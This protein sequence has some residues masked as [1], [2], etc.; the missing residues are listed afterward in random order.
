MAYSMYEATVP[1]LAHAL[2]SLRGVLQKGEQWAADKGV[3]PEVLL[4]TRLVLDMLPLSRQ[5]LR[6]L[7]GLSLIHI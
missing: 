7:E 5:V 4:G 3:A 1:V 2:R 6:T